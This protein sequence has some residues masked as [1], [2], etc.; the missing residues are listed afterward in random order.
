MMNRR[1]H[2]PTARLAR[3]AYAASA[4]ALL[5]ACGCAHQGATYAGTTGGVILAQVGEATLREADLPEQTQGRLFALDNAYAQQRFVTLWT[6]VEDAIGEQLLAAEARRRGVPVTRLLAAEVDEKVGT[7]SDGELRDIYDSNR[8][9]I[10]VPF[11]E[12]AP[13]LR[14]QVLRERAQSLRR[15]LVD[16]LRQRQDVALSLPLPDLR[17][18]AV[19]ADANAPS[20]GPAAAPVTLVV[21]S[22]FQCPYSAQARRLVRR[23]SELYPDDLRVVL[24]QFP[25]EQHGNAAR[26]AEASLCAHA[27]KRFWPLYEQL[28]ENTGHLEQAALPG[29]VEAAQ[30]DAAAFNACMGQGA[31]KEALRRDVLEGQALGIKGTPAMY[32][33]GM[34]L[35]GVLPLPVMQAL[36]AREQAQAGES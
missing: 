18:V 34:P 27:Q 21:F 35:M 26:A 8:T 16:R 24:R 22:D 32:L 30:L 5:L 33:N 28:F 31:T 25:L 14:E 13:Y 36:V 17:R 15:A 12:A 19:T 23:L 2:T 6:G 20:L 9:T 1:R 4:A 3:R 7:V 29:Y 10:G 11:A